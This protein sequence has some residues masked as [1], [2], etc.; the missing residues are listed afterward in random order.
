MGQGDDDASLRSRLT[1]D[2]ADDIEPPEP[3]ETR[4]WKE[5]KEQVNVKLLKE[6]Q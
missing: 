6:P 1:L 2:T 3:T 5:R 4:D